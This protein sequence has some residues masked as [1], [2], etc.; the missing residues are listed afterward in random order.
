MLVVDDG[1]LDVVAACDVG[2]VVDE[3]VAE[4]PDVVVV[5]RDDDDVAVLCR[6][7]PF[8]PL[9]PFEPVER[10]V[11]GTCVLPLVSIT[12]FAEPG[13]ACC[14]MFHLASSSLNTSAASR[15]PPSGVKCTPSSARTKTRFPLASGNDAE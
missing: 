5:L 3:L 9:E 11:P 12:C 13:T 7:E 8:E 2:G 14:V 6:V 15:S 10:L 1:A 4:R